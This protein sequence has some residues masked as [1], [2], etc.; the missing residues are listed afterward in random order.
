MIDDSIV[1]PSPI[2]KPVK[3]QNAENKPPS[4]YT[5]AL[6][7]RLYS[8]FND[9]ENRLTVDWIEF[10]LPC[11]V[12]WREWPK[13]F[14]ATYLLDAV[15][16]P[17]GLHGYRSQYKFGRMV[18]L[19]NGTPEMGHHVIMGGECLRDLRIEPVLLLGMVREFGGKITRLDLALDDYQQYIC[20]DRL[21]SWL[22]SGR[23][24][25]KSRQY[26]LVE[27]GSLD[28][29]SEVRRTLYVGS[30]KSNVFWRI[31][32]KA[33]ELRNKKKSETTLDWLRWEVQLRADRAAIIAEEIIKEQS[34]A[35]VFGALLGGYISIRDVD[36]NDSNR[37]RW[38]V[39]KAWADFVGL[40]AQWRWGL[41]KPVKQ[42]IEK[43]HWFQRQVAPTF[44]AIL[45]AFGTEEMTRLFKEG[46]RRLR[47]D[48]W[49]MITLARM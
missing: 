44:A 15:A 13:R 3:L 21:L 23:M 12:D 46:D 7:T 49:Q 22:R 24:V 11:N 30:G 42:L 2:S 36:V 5:G 31:Y 37:S 14:E 27:G 45:R 32:E 47:A 28:N 20:M 39:T 19:T 18:V 41:Q 4:C 25:C 29:Q 26:Q 34:V 48:H 35:I 6:N 8:G 16:C 17:R 40:V 1:Y 43:V 10:T 38:T 9:L 33:R